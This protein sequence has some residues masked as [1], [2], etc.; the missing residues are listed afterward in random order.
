MLA[1]DIWQELE[2]L[3]L[4][5]KIRVRELI[6]ADRDGVFAAEPVE[7]SGFEPPCPIVVRFIR[8]NGRGEPLL[9]R[10]LEASFFDHP[11]LLR[12][13]GA[14][15]V[16]RGSA[17]F[18]YAV[19]EREDA[20]LADYIRTVP[21][22][23]SE[24]R[25]LGLE[26]AAALS[27]L[28][29]RSLVY[30]NLDAPSV[31]RV[32]NA[33][34]LS[35]YSQMRVVGNNY[36]AET[37]RLMAVTPSTPPE[38]YEGM[39]TPSWDVWSLAC[40][41]TAA[42]SGPKS[43]DSLASRRP[44]PDLPAPFA[45]I[46]AECL[47]TNPQERCSLDRIRQL[48]EQSAEEPTPERPKFAPAGV[49]AVQD[50]LPA[51]RNS[52]QRVPPA[53]DG[54]P[55]SILPAAH[56]VMNPYEAARER[57]RARRHGRHWMLYA[58][59]AGAALGILLAVLFLRDS[60]PP[61]VSARTA[62]GDG[63][64]ASTSAKTQPSAPSPNGQQAT[65]GPTRG[66]SDRVAP[67]PPDDQSAIRSLL[68]NWAAASR[69][70]DVDA[71]ASFYT[72]IVDRY[73]GQRNVPRDRIKRE[74]QQA[75]EKLGDVRLYDISNIHVQLTGPNTAVATFD[76]AWDF[77]SSKGSYAGKVKQQVS[78]RKMDGVWRIATERDIHVYR[79]GRSGSSRSG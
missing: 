69:S 61:N 76:K 51:G 71:Q 48:L 6:S 29:E 77:A 66:E 23:A 4:D 33:W 26:I 21:L 67:A 59:A 1:R 24:A 68:E 72:P 13:F 32:G 14:G 54:A 27:Y 17:R 28:H 40:V 62:S 47:N 22:P 18:I 79:R 25:A 12:C 55:A 70:R 75:L 74:R 41:L 30:C 36:A 15:A 50:R 56:V 43:E 2:G 52:H 35:D 78:L 45:S 42:L 60:P 9:D 34:K 38:A 63:V 3:I 73:Y 37:R 44:K 19:L 58:V 10:F 49:S 31:A 64:S 39:V 57:A 46:T 20:T 65:R 8:E 53:R 11:N 16:E 5:E 7:A